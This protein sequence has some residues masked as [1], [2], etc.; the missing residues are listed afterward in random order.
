MNRSPTPSPSPSPII[1]NDGLYQCMVTDTKTGYTF[2]LTSLEYNPNSPAPENVTSGYYSNAKVY[3]N[4]CNLVS[5]INATS[6]YNDGA[7]VCFEVNGQQTNYGSLN[8]LHFIPYLGK[9]N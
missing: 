3:M 4:F 2:N 1:L 9:Y 5:S 7:A 8:G 6:C